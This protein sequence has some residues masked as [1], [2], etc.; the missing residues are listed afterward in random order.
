MNSCSQRALFAT[1]THKHTFAMN[2]QLTSI[3]RG[4]EQDVFDQ[5]RMLRLVLQVLRDDRCTHGCRCHTD[6]G[7]RITVGTLHSVHSTASVS[8]GRIRR[9][10]RTL[11]TRNR[12]P[13][14]V[15]THSPQWSPVI[16]AT[17]SSVSVRI[18]QTRKQVSTQ[19]RSSFL[20]AAGLSELQLR[21]RCADRGCADTT[22][23]G[24]YNWNEWRY[25]PHRWSTAVQYDWVVPKLCRRYPTHS[26][27]AGNLVPE[28]VT[29]THVALRSVLEQLHTI[30]LHK[31]A[32][33]RTSGNGSAKL[34]LWSV[35]FVS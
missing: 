25:P 34:L 14:T 24:L 33:E 17:R 7:L 30:G 3:A 32:S 22:G 19:Q 9:Y 18:T 10:T 1:S 16:T 11:K 12:L 2:C 13:S 20:S 35:T 28:C 6:D 31:D 21:A 4:V 8:D 23:Y 26:A 29:G 5:L 15:Q 27:H